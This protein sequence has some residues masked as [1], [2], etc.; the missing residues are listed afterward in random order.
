MYVRECTRVCV[1]T[2]ICE[3]AVVGR[4]LQQN[5]V[6]AQW[7]WRHGGMVMF[8]GDSEALLALRI[9]LTPHSTSHADAD[10][11]RPQSRPHVDRGND[12]RSDDH[13]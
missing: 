5:G 3:I 2:M 4:W 6:V 12:G 10:G 8:R 13:S 9:A 7:M 11:V 1:C